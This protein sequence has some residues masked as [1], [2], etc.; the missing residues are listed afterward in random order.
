MAEKKCKHCAMMIPKEAK[1]CPHCRKKQGVSFIVGAFIVIIGIFIFTGIITN[2]SNKST[3]DNSPT[4]NES[5]TAKG[6]KV[7][8]K[9]ASWPNDI[10]N[11]VA[12]KKI[13][14]GM[15][16]DQVIAAWG[17][18]Y[19]INET[20]GSWGTHEQWVMSRGISSD[21]LYFENGILKT[22]QQS[23]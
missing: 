5:L 7:K 16:R 23:K 4:S 22:M 11:T 2:I 10:C 20:I 6:Q 9:H 12:E 17:K 8:K 18:P 3:N 1:I 21:Y 15:D 14:V 13:H 19:K